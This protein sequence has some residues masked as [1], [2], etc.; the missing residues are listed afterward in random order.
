MTSVPAVPPSIIGN[1]LLVKGFWRVLSNPVLSFFSILPSS[2]YRGEEITDIAMM[3]A[4][5]CNA[6]H[7]SDFRYQTQS[8][9]YEITSFLLRFF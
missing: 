6:L 4:K 9:A 7:S 8:D 5:Q 3:Y 2:K 1:A